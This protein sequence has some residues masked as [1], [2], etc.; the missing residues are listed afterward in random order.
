MDK[1]QKK[2][3]IVCDT[4]KNKYVIVFPPPTKPEKS[5][6]PNAKKITDFF[7]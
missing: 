5:N 3:D 2:K 6:Q 7:K 1:K 4:K